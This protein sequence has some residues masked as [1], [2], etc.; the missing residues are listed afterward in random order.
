MCNL[1]AIT[2]SQEAI[3]QAAKALRDKAGNVPS[4]PS[5]FP[6]Q[7][8]PIVRVGEDGKR[9]LI[10]M[11]W[12]FPSPPVFGNP[13]PVTN[14]RNVKS[15]YWK[16]W[17]KPEQRCLVPAT[18]FCEYH[19]KADP[20]TKRKVPHWFALSEK[21][22]IFFFAGIWRTWNG[23][24]GTKA[25]P[26]EGKHVIFSFLTCDPNKIVKPVHSKAMPVILTTK[27][28]CDE[29]LSAPVEKALKLQRPLADKLLK[30][31]ATGEK[32]DAA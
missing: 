14:V 27:A 11:R 26:V 16:P 9:E 10:M 20:K 30:V 13:R 2:K 31:V 7:M 17:L 8:A 28:E 5:I 24:R 29:W 1:Y 19:D 25:D 4:L 23:T 15:N 12:G 6:D 32:M 18:S 21:R 3:R 22:P